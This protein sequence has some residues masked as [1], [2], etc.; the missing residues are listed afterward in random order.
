MLG[1]P[2]AP[3]LAQRPPA[4]QKMECARAPRAHHA[5]CTPGVCAARVRVIL[6][7]DSPLHFRRTARE[8]DPHAAPVAMTLPGPAAGHRTAAG[9]RASLIEE[10]VRAPVGRG[11][12]PASASTRI[13]EARWLS[14]AW[15][16]FFLVHEAHPPLR[17]FKLVRGRLTPGL[18]SAE[19]YVREHA[20]SPECGRPLPD[21]SSSPPGRVSSF[22]RPDDPG[23]PSVSEGVQPSEGAWGI[24]PRLDVGPVGAR[25]R[26]SASEAEAQVILHLFA[27]PEPPS[28]SCPGHALPD[29]RFAA[30]RRLRGASRFLD[31]RSARSR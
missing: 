17:F 10:M 23:G 13:S 19:T 6:A 9:R 21:A 1:D 11:V 2:S 12:S 4:A 16:E 24:L 27:C 25:C 3:A 15:L 28:S 8:K 20:R 29:A 30:T 26:R 31:G 22:P 7:R 5:G 18:P 14:R